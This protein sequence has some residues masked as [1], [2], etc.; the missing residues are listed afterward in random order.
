MEE[1]GREREKGGDKE[2]KGRNMAR[3]M[4]KKG[5]KKGK[6]NEEVGR[7]ITQKRRGRR[8]R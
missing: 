7:K 4:D 1:G 2:V 5:D 3:G 8:S 6:D